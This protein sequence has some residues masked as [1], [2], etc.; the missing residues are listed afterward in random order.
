MLGKYLLGLICLIKNNGIKEV[1]CTKNV[2]I[3]G[4]EDKGD[5]VPSPDECG[6]GSN[7]KGVG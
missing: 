1:F 5:A 2:I 4:K 3:A 7:T 6:L